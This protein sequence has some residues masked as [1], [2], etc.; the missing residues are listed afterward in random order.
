MPV[1]L[2]KSF[3]KKRRTTRKHRRVINDVGGGGWNA[4]FASKSVPRSASIYRARASRRK[5]YLASSGAKAKSKAV[6][7]PTIAQMASLAAEKAMSMTALGLGFAPSGAKPKAV[8]RPSIA[9][10]ASLAAEKARSK[11]ARRRIT[12]RMASLAAEEARAR[13]SRRR[14][15][16]GPPSKSRRQG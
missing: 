9:H 8:I 10:L 11:T 7:R 1:K 14:P 4:A 3:T 12:T 6:R 15:T 16:R 13:A 5:A 2:K